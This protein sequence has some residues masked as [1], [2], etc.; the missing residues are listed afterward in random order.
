[1]YHADIVT[2]EVISTSPAVIVERLAW[3][4]EHPI[5][6]VGLSASAG[7]V[8]MHEGNLYR[9]LQSH[10][11]QSD[12]IPATTPAL[13]VRYYDTG[14]IPA[15]VQPVGGSDAYIL[16]A[17]VTHAGHT[18]TNLITA[19]VWEPGSV[20]AETLWHCEDCTPPVG[21]WAVGVLYHVDDHVMH[22]GIEYRCLQQ[23]TSIASW[24]PS[25]P[26][27]LGVLWALV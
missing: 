26:G 10:T 16:G 4:C 2:H 23:H 24:S 25:S 17:K 1:M 18:Y 7:Q 3:V 20:G 9:C 21:I 12:W 5:W 27:I 13:W 19:N 8:W 22:L 6:G 11:T 14:T 15:W